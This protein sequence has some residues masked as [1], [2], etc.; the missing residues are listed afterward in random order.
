MSRENSNSDGTFRR[1]D[2]LKTTA[3]ATGVGAF[4]IQ[5]ARA[6][7]RLGTVRFAQ[8]GIVHDV[9]EDHEDLITVENDVA[10]QHVVDEQAGVFQFTPFA[11]EQTKS[12]IKSNEEI[13]FEAQGYQAPPSQTVGGAPSTRITTGLSTDFRTTNYVPITEQYTPEQF[14][15]TTRGG[16]VEVSSDAAQLTV[17]PGEQKSVTLDKETARGKAYNDTGV[18]E[19]T[20][21]PR[22]EVRNFGELDVLDQETL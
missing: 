16:D 14:A 21:V 8:A 5:A 17:T 22:L 12:A 1:R 20:V 13:I 19:I 18:R 6:E 15:I 4:G 11:T 10:P 7:S 9:V 3:V 2:F